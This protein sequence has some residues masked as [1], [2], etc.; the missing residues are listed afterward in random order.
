LWEIDILLFL[1]GEDSYGVGFRPISSVGCS[2]DRLTSAEDNEEASLL[3]YPPIGLG[4][5]RI[6]AGP[7]E[8]ERGLISSDILGLKRRGFTAESGNRAVREGVNGD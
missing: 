3:G 8:K 5:R 6:I 7:K 1:K 2:H 4:D